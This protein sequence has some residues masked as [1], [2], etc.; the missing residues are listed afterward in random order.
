MTYD[1]LCGK[2]RLVRL[3]RMKTKYKKKKRVWKLQEAKARFSALVG[4]YVVEGPQQISVHGKLKAVLLSV[5]E[6]E[7]M[8]KRKPSFVEF[9]E[10]SPWKGEELEIKRDKSKPRDIEL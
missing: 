5:E 7:K 10:G 3:V 8:A 1:E 2:L 9:M 6:Y 4:K